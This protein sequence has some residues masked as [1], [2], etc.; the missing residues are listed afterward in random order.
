MCAEQTAA[1]CFV[2]RNKMHDRMDA[3]CHEDLTSC[4]WNAARYAKKPLDY[5]QVSDCAGYK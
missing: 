1:G 2:Y 5:E 4:T 3:S